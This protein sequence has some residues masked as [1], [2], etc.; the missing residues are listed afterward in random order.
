VVRERQGEGPVS[1]LDQVVRSE[2]ASLRRLAG[3]RV[4]HYIVVT[5]L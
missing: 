3:Q 1:W 4:R 2:E 5:L